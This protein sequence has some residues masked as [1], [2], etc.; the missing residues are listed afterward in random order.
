[1][2]R[3][4]QIRRGAASALAI[5]SLTLPA[6]AVADDASTSTP[7]TFADQTLQLDSHRASAADNGIVRTRRR[8]RWGRPYTV[9][10]KGTASYYSPAAYRAP[11]RPLVLC[12][13]PELGAMFRSGGTA[14]GPVGVDPEFVLAR[15]WTRSQCSRVPGHWS[16]FQIRTSRYFFH[17]EPRGGIGAAARSD[18]TY[19][20]TI[21]GRGRAVSFRLVD[22]AG[23]QD[24]YGVFRIAIQ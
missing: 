6:D 2:T 13:K 11:R 8:L 14:N 15:P 7:A 21:I 22:R 9:T 12:G 23:A 16:N 20:Y 24:N 3:A 5:A 4:T 18:H 19:T 17:P 1:M 10:V